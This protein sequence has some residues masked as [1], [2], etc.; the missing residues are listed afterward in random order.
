MKISTKGRYALRV[1]VDLAEN[2][3]GNYIAM[4]E[5]ANRQQISLKYL[6]KILPVLVKNRFIEGTSG[7]G[8]GYKLTKQPNQYK[9]GKILELVEGS[10]APVECIKN[11]GLMC[12]HYSECRTLTLWKNLDKVVNDYLNSVLLSDLM[13]KKQL[14][15]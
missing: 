2:S 1:M 15:V 8:G 14:V 9:V 6:E 7:K 10:L 5:I 12:L 4:K 11:G 3:E 13:Q